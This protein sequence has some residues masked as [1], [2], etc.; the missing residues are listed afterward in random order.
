[1]TQTACWKCRKNYISAFF[2]TTLCRYHFVHSKDKSNLHLHGALQSSGTAGAKHPRTKSTVQRVAPQHGLQ[3]LVSSLPFPAAQDKHKHLQHLLPKEQRPQIQ[4]S[5]EKRYEPAC[6]NTNT[7]LF[8]LSRQYEKE[9]N[10][11]YPAG[12]WKKLWIYQS[13]LILNSQLSF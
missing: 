4:H 8:V 11:K 1:M 9:N 7:G 12:S 6:I 5:S 10:K 3:D 13:W 2:S